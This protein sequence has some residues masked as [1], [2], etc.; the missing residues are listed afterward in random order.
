MKKTIW[1]ISILT[2]L[3]VASVL[4][5]YYDKSDKC[6][7]ILKVTEVE[8]NLEEMENKLIGVQ[9]S[10]KEIKERTSNPPSCEEL[11]QEWMMMNNFDY[12]LESLKEQEVYLE[13][14]L[15]DAEKAAKE[16]SWWDTYSS[17]EESYFCESRSITSVCDSLSDGIGTR[18]YLTE[19]K[20]SWK[21]CKE[22]WVA[23]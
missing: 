20:D 10:I 21:Y 9:N 1:I 13:K 5:Y 15:I 2:F 4:G 18:C 6:G 7:Y 12:E 11:L 19:E 8:V 23:I 17:S 3:F 14:E 16:S 22:G